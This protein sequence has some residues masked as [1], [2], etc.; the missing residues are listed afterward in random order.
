MKKMFVGAAG[1]AIWE[2]SGAVLV[3]D[4]GHTRMDACHDRT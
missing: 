4:P 1:Q 2:S 3:M